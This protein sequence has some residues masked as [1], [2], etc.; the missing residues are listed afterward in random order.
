[1]IIFLH[2]I[3][4]SREDSEDLSTHRSGN[5]HSNKGTFNGY[6]SEEYLD[7]LEPNGNIPPNKSDLGFTKRKL[8]QIIMYHR[9]YYCD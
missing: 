3:A 5:N 1:M 9:F 2:S 7:R 4:I 8:T 6:N